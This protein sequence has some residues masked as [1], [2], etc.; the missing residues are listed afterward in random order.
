MWSKTN[1]EIPKLEFE[2]RIERVR[3]FAV[4]HNLSGVVVYSAPKIHQWNQTGHVGY[5][6]NWSNLDRIVDAM[7]VVPVKGKASLL[8]AGVEYMLDQIEEVSWIGEVRLVSS[9]DPRSISSSFDAS[10]VGEDANQGVR[11][12]GAEISEI[13]DATGSG[14][15]PVGISG[16]EALPVNIY[17]DLK[18][19]LK[20]Q[21]A[22]V[23]DIVAEL[24]QYKTPQEL[25][26]MKR[27]AAISD[28][29]YQRMLEV[30]SEGIWGYE[31]TAEMDCVAKRQGAD[32]VY[33]CMHSAPGNNLK[34]GK[35][36]VKSHDCQ[37]KRGDYINVNAYVVYKG[38][39]IQSDR[40][41][42][43]GPSLDRVTLKMVEP[44]LQVQNEVL[45]AIRPGLSINE[46]INIG[47][48]AAARFG[49]E[50][51]GGRIGH[52]QGLDYS[53]RPFLLAGSQE[54]LQPGHVFVLHVCLGEP[55]GTLLINPIADLCHV[56]TDGVEVLNRFPRELFHVE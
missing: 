49:F 13:L 55:G 7:V 23:P 8:V 27:V 38:Y 2:N 21:I 56:T 14:G 11:S 41:G 22:Q 30:L 50:I 34:A 16:L 39:W 46:L 4:K 48:K 43:I 36:S 53:E 44:N 47:N 9:P 18:V 24:R 6:T 3:S 17:R 32:F 26:L 25:V 52:G 33:H 28:S 20:D 37:L 12:F 54:I 42:T 19:N 31:L 1:H 5:L 29:S 40:A 10:V 35:L 45:K 51:Q 15:K